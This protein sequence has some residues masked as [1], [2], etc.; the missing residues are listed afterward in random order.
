MEIAHDREK[1]RTNNIAAANVGTEISKTGVAVVGIAAG[2]IG[3]WA[4]ANLISGT[5][6]SGGP[7]NLVLS[8]FKTING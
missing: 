4:V 2:I 6:H 5:M 1:S 7:L 3:F 8:L